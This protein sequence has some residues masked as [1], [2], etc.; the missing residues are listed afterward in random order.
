MEEKD[1]ESA[2]AERVGVPLDDLRQ[3]LVAMP[4]L[5]R[6]IVDGVRLAAQSGAVKAMVEPVMA[7]LREMTPEDR[8]LF[9][10][11]MFVMSGPMSGAGLR[12]AAVPTDEIV[13]AMWGGDDREACTSFDEVVA[14]HAEEEAEAKE[15]GEETPEHTQLADLRRSAEA[16]R[17]LFLRELYTEGR[18]VVREDAANSVHRA[19]EKLGLAWLPPDSPASRARAELFHALGAF[20][21]AEKLVNPTVVRAVEK[22]L[23]SAVANLRTLPA[24]PDP[25]TARATVDRLLAAWEA[26]HTVKGEEDSR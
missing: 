4:Q 6:S 7:T 16:I 22:H 21:A 15:A 11:A 19:A 10:A 3:A 12:I 23:E 24:K 1:G 25:I 14:E 8:D 20:F 18:L 9:T 26:V 2:L 5:L 13:R 17:A